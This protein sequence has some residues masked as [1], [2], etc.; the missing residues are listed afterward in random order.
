MV[1]VGGQLEGRYATPTSQDGFL[2]VDTV[3]NRLW[4]YVRD[5]DR[6][7]WQVC[8]DH[9]DSLTYPDG[10][11]TGERALDWDRIPLEPGAG[12]NVVPV[13]EAEENHAAAPVDDGFDEPIPQ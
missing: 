3:N 8:T 12:P 6:G 9:D 10:P 5:D 4:V 11:H 1:C 7:V 2:A 13:V